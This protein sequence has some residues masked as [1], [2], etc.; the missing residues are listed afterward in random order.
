MNAGI[1]PLILTPNSSSK[2]HPLRYWLLTSV[3]VSSL[4]EFGEV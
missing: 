2:L 1:E 3:D 4:F